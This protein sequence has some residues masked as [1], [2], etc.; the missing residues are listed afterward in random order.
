LVYWQPTR[1]STAAVREEA[2]VEALISDL[3]A[4]R[5]AAS[6]SVARPFAAQASK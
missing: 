1:D 3:L 5:F 6:P 2:P 4:G